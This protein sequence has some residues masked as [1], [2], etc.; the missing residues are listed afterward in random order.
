MQKWIETESRTM[1]KWCQTESH[2]KSHLV[3]AW[4]MSKNKSK[5]LDW[6]AYD[7]QHGSGLK[8][9]KNKSEIFNAKTEFRPNR[10]RKKT[11]FQAES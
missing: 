6:I 4:N 8:T 2:K 3:S 10:T 9:S 5:H 11:C 7:S 1:D